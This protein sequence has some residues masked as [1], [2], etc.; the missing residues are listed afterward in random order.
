MGSSA[1]EGF[2]VSLKATDILGR[3]D[4]SREHGHDVIPDDTLT[5]NVLIEEAIARYYEAGT[6][7]NL[8]GVLDAILQRSRAGGHF[9]I[10]VIPPQAMFD[11]ID[12]DHVKAG[13]TVTSQEEM[14]FKLHHI[15]TNDGKMW[16]A[17]IAFL[18]FA[19]GNEGAVTE[20]WDL[21][22][23]GRV[24]GVQFEHTKAVQEDFNSIFPRE[25][26]P[27]F[28]DVHYHYT[29]SDVGIGYE[30]NLEF[31]IPDEE[32][33]RAYAASVAPPEAFTI[34]PYDEDYLEYLPC[35][36]FLSIID[37]DN[38]I[39]EIFQH[40]GHT[41]RFKL[42]DVEDGKIVEEQI[43]TTNGSGHGALA[44]FLKAAQV[45]ALICGGIGM[46]AQNALAEA[47]IKLYGGV[48]G[49][50]DAAARAL[51]EGTLQY[52]PNAQCDHHG[53]HHGEG[54]ECGHHH[55]EGHDCG[56]HRG[57]GLDCG[58]QEGDDGCRRHHG[59]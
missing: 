13:D 15:Q 42:Y 12:I 51:A 48:S 35:E 57:K 23:Y 55:G 22:D 18:C 39:Q 11:M 41:E 59:D 14:H 52:D 47:G 9:L 30:F 8:I 7:Q 44:G 17:G 19:F 49:S 56:H 3:F 38:F 2:A 53:H 58:H 31:T 54:H 6:R 43:V 36:N 25:I 5:G 24:Y 27:S 16:L 29:A 46:G 50:A 21:A 28:E 45:D 4:I 32:Q 40:F 20:T 37:E 33:F 10:P 26:S 1:R 34:F